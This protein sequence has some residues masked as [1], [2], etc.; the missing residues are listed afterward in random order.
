MKIKILHIFSAIAIFCFYLA[1]CGNPTRKPEDCPASFADYAYGG[2]SSMRTISLP[3]KWQTIDEIPAEIKT[4]SLEIAI[5]RKIRNQTEIWLKGPDSNAYFDRKSENYKYFTYTIE[6]KEWREISAVVENTN[7][8]AMRL[9]L[10]QDGSIWAQNFWD[11]QKSVGNANQK[12]PILSKFNDS[13]QTFELVP[14]TQGIQA[15]NSLNL[16]W[17]K[18][19]YSGDV[20][21]II[22][23]G[24]SIYSYDPDSIKITKHIEI[25]NIEIDYFTFSKDTD[26]IYL[27]TEHGIS[28]AVKKGEY[29]QYFPEN[30]TLVALDLPTVSGDGLKVGI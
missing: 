8:F 6:E 16:S 20:F 14:E 21:W 2:S 13:K 18:I 10:S 19:F 28:F 7:A 12:Y 22:S 9:F 29:L 27:Q 5:I 3:E 15:Y 24:D 17:N 30:N 26:V 1:S 23:Q 4:S 25:P 11:V